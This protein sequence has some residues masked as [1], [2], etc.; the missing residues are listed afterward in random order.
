[1]GKSPKGKL[2]WL[3]VSMALSL[4]TT[5]A[6]GQASAQSQSPSS[7]AVEINP[8]PNAAPHH[9]YRFEFHA[10]NG[11]PPFTWSLVKGE[12]PV[13][14]KLSA[15]GVLAG[16]AIAPG[17]FHFTVQVTDT[18][19]P[20]Q[21]A[22]RDV[23][24]KVVPP[25]LLEWKDYAKV[26]ANRIDGKV[27][28]SNG[29]DDDFDLTFVVLAV[30]ENGRATAI[31]YQRFSLTHGTTSFEIPFGETLPNGSYVVH[32]DTVAEVPEKDQIYRA[33]LQTKEPL[34]VIVGP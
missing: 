28:V 8:L 15:D 3:A 7:V 33:R 4:M 21:T 19:R 6:L 25:L 30:A 18:S 2:S 9:P 16:S 1:M 5:S 24:L 32:V 27:K 13:G 22:T 23:E 11:I 29:T 34:Q 17:T 10:R 14:M 12:G 31:G 26:S 20:P